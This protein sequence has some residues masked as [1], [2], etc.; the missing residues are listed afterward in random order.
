MRSSR[1]PTDFHEIQIL[2]LLD[3]QPLHSAYSIAE[4]LLVS[5][6]TILDPAQLNNQFATDSDRNWLRVI[7]DS[8]GS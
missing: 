6:S 8:Q 2:A 1:P 3:E 5:H 7:A 4:A